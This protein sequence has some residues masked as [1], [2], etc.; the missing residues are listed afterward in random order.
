MYMNETWIH[1]HVNRFFEEMFALIPAPLL[2]P[3]LARPQGG[4]FAPQSS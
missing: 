3:Q 4:T 2:K 1:L